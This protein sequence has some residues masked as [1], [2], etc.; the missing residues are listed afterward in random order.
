[1]SDL[2]GLNVF[3]FLFYDMGKLVRTLAS[4]LYWLFSSLS[5]LFIADGVMYPF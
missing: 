4:V 1:M 3:F 5:G 2:L